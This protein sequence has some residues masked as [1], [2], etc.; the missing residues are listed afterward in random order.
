MALINGNLRRALAFHVDF[1][2]LPSVS[3]PIPTPTPDK[4]IKVFVMR[5]HVVNSV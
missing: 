4:P 3:S 5:I 1:N 2:Y